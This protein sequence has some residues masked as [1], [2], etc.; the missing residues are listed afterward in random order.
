MTFPTDSQ[1]AV[2]RLH[3]QQ[4]TSFTLEVRMG[5]MTT[6]PRLPP[7]T[8]HHLPRHPS[9]FTVFD[10]GVA[11]EMPGVVRTIRADRS[12]A[13]LAA[14]AR[15]AIDAEAHLAGCQVDAT[16]EDGTITLRG[17]VNAYFQR[18]AAERA[19]RFLDG[20]HAIENR[21]LVSPP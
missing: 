12:D 7:G 20:C 9:R 4:V 15:R 8:I 19:M 11:S 10:N 3:E 14:L 5:P 6:D 2:R 18:A 1:H 13:Q 17:R 21:I 16:V